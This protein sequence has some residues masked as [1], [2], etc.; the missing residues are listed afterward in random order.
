MQLCNMGASIPRIRHS[1]Y[2]LQAPV[3]WVHVSGTHLRARMSSNVSSCNCTAACSSTRHSLRSKPGVCFGLP[4]LQ[5]PKTCILHTALLTLCLFHFLANLWISS[6]SLFGRRIIVKDST[7][8]IL[9]ADLIL[10]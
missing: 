6:P 10:Y 7:G 8:W 2:I 9:T 1:L 4:P 5:N 3:F